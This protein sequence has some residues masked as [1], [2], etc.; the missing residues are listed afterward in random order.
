MPI[1]VALYRKFQI[2]IPVLITMHLCTCVMGSEI[3]AVVVIHR[4]GARPPLTKEPH[5]PSSETPEG[6]LYPQGRKQLQ[7]LGSFVKNTYGSGI[8]SDRVIA[9]SSNLP[10]TLLSS[11]A[12][13]AGLLPDGTYMDVPTLVLNSSESDWIIRGYANCPHLEDN[14][15]KF[16]ETSEYQNWENNYASFVEDLAAK[17]NTEEFDHTF[18]NVFNVYDRYVLVQDEYDSTPDGVQ[19]SKL[20]DE[21]M[22]KLK[23]VADWYESSKFINC[24]SDTPVAGGLLREILSHLSKAT[25]RDGLHL[26]EYSAHYPTL[27]TL[28]AEIQSRD[29]RDLL[30]EIPGFGAAL[31]VELH[32]DD[33]NNF[34]VFLKWFAGG[35]VSEISTRS[36][37]GKCDGEVMENNSEG[38]P[39]E[40]FLS[41]FE[42]FVELSDYCQACQS[43][44]G[45]CVNSS[46]RGLNKFVLLIIGLAVGII[47]GI[48]LAM[49]LARVRRRKSVIPPISNDAEDGCIVD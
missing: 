5:D 29:S 23:T 40:N 21:Q 32:E 20:P 2:A 37:S 7:D 34:R 48:L 28:L 6:G 4:H 16:T 11:R 49:T 12:F 1:D 41:Q 19:I 10:R 15:L 47:L 3:R 39:L 44:Q 31:F 27:L 18:Q 9:F 33:D 46:S 38:C 14:I 24:T 8:S 43:D 17:L 45:A 22:K 26:F 13:L 42:P 35:L 36:I 25:E 30:R